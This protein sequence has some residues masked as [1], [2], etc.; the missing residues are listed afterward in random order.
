[1]VRA[2]SL[3]LGGRWCCQENS[4]YYGRVAQ[5]LE[6]R[7]YTSVVPGSN[8]G[9][10]TKN[11]FSWQDSSFARNHPSKLGCSLASLAVRI[12]PPLPFMPY[13]LFGLL[14]LGFGIYFLRI[15]IR[16]KDKEG[17]IGMVAIIIAALFLILFFGLFFRVLF[18]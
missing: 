18:D 14:L 17:L 11:E 1:M 13:F 16:E 12:H 15:T 3:Y 4:F 5:R 9:T 6:H 8:P 7:A 2:P 10:P